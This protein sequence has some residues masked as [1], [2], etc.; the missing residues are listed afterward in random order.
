LEE[1]L[2]VYNFEVEDYHSYFVGEFGVLVHNS[3]DA[4]GEAGKGGSQAGKYDK[5]SLWERLT[6]KKTNVDNLSPNPLDEFSNPKIGPSDSAV[7]KYMKEIGTTGKISEPITVQKLTSG[8]Y[9]IVNGHHRW[10]AAIKTGLKQV[11]IKIKN[12]N[13]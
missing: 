5:A 2:T 7:S 4:A 13:N 10:L 1:P 6:T 9:E 12:Y 8:G 3:Y 11:P